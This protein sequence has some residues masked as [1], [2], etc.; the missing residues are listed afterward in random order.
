MGPWPARARSCSPGSSATRSAGRFW[1]QI[2]ET[3]RC[4][5]AGPRLGGRG[6]IQRNDHVLGHRPGAPASRRGGRRLRRGHAWPLSAAIDAATRRAQRRSPNPN[7]G[8]DACRPLDRGSR[9]HGGPGPLAGP[10][11][12]H[13]SGRP[14]PAAGM[15]FRSG[16]NERGSSTCARRNGRVRSTRPWNGRTRIIPICYRA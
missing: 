3:C 14:R 4:R 6:G 7:A 16:T 8:R 9:L 12:R 10:W 1:A 5:C 11:S 13:R 15:R 2:G